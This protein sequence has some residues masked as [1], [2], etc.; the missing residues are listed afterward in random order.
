MEQPLT[1]SE[2]AS[3]D[4]NVPYVHTPIDCSPI[5][6]IYITLVYTFKK[7]YINYEKILA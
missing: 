3:G 5:L 7:N 4:S 2:A 6:S 1:I